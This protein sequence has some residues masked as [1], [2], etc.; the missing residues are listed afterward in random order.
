VISAA[1]DARLGGVEWAVGRGQALE[2]AGAKR[3][4]AEVRRRCEDAGLVIC[5][6]SAQDSVLALDSPFAGLVSLAAELGAPHVRILAPPYRGGDPDRAMHEL[7]EALERGVAIAAAAGIVLL[8]EAVPGSVLACTALARRLLSA[9]P[10][11]RVGAVYDPASMIIE[12]HLAPALAIG[13]LGPYLR[14]VHVKNVGWTRRR[15]GS[16][17]PAHVRLDTGLVDWAIVFAS[18]RAAGYQGW[19][20]IDHLPRRPSPAALREETE[21]VRK[22]AATS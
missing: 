7:S 2:L 16:W 6:L 15:D 12:G 14:L 4:V 3:E 1:V 11:D 9:H 19:L 21:R 10:T 22:L 13:L 20:T 8:I 5:G 17:H 18:L